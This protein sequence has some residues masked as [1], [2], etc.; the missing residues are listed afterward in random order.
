M[1]SLA[2]DGAD[3]DAEDGDTNAE[4]LV[5]QAIRHMSAAVE[6]DGAPPSVNDLA[7]RLY[8]SRS[9]LCDTFKRVT[10]QSVGAYARRLRLARACRLLKDESLTVAEVAAL[11]GYPSPSAFCHAFASAMG[12]P[13]QG[14]RDRAHVTPCE[15]G[16]SNGAP[17]VDGGPAV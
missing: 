4:M 8:M 14:W 6:E 2:A 15:A 17:A 12:I 1:A 7:R 11:L 9:R 5:E 3:G 10:G 13:P 16:T